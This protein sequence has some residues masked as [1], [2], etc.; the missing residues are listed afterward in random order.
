LA[1]PHEFLGLVVVVG[2]PSMVIALGLRLAMT[3]GAVS[4]SRFPLLSPT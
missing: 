3:I 2:D 1:I 4:A